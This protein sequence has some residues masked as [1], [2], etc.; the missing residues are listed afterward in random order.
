MAW[1]MYA[2]K[3]MDATS[4][5]TQCDNGDV[6][7]NNDVDIISLNFPARYPLLIAFARLFLLSSL[8]KSTGG[9]PK[10]IVYF[11]FFQLIFFHHLST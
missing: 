11:G 2:S 6:D 9:R 10:Q 3:A 8:A 7:E 5:Q 1:E 4:N